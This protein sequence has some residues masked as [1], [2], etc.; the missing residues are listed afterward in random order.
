MKRRMESAQLRMTREDPALP[1]GKKRQ[2]KHLDEKLITYLVSLSLEFRTDSGSKERSENENPSKRTRV[3]EVAGPSTKS[4]TKKR[5]I[6]SAEL[7]IARED[8][9]LPAKIKRKVKHLEEK[10][11]TYSSTSSLEY[12]TDSNSSVGIQTTQSSMESEPKEISEYENQRKTT[13]SEVNGPSTSFKSKK[14]RMENVEDSTAA[15]DFGT[16]S[17]KRKAGTENENEKAKFQEKYVELDKLGEGGFGSVFAGY[18]REDN[19]PVA[20]KH[21]PKENVILKHTDENG[22][23]LP[24]EVAIMLK[25]MNVTDEPS[26]VVSLFDWYDLGHEVILVMERPLPCDDL[27]SYLNNR[28]RP[29]KDKEAKV[30][31]KQLVKAAIYLKNKNI[32]HK[33]IKSDN[34]LIKTDSEEPQIYLID[35]GVSCF[36]E[37]K[38]HEVFCGAVIEAPVDWFVLGCCEAEPVTVWQ[39]GV[40]LFELLHNK[41]FS[42]KE[43]MLEWLK[44][45]KK[46]SKKGKDFLTK[47][48]VISLTKTK[49]KYFR[50]RTFFTERKLDETRQKSPLM[51]NNWE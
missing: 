11:I 51:N 18:R 44:I 42:T 36:D 22:K 35:F 27:K 7:R 28:R 33:D 46:L 31:L 8:P 2:T 1:A 5:R 37:G 50:Q 49:R 9:A 15:K 20:I 21:I 29:L 24:M 25:L 39:I 32:F 4:K 6:E 41:Y 16:K 45:S 13:A 48:A 30:I 14:R 26:F 47:L 10:P 17:L 43:Q 40:V 19:S 12:S 23:E 34:I 38:P 3:S